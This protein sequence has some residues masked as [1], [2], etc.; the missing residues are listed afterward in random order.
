[1]AHGG[2][3]A[4]DMTSHKGA[5]PASRARTAALGTRIDELVS[6][7][8]RMGGS[9]LH[10]KVGVPPGIRAQGLLR[11]L[12]EYGGLR[13]EDTESLLKEILPK[14]MATEFEDEGE[15][16]FSYEVS[17]LGRFRVNAFRQRGS[18]SI[19]M[20]YIPL[21]VPKFEELALPEVIR[22]LA[23][24]ERGIILV[25]GTTGSGKSTTLASM[26]DLVNHSMHK[27]IVTI[28]DP[29]E[30]LHRDDKSFI[31]QREVGSDTAS[32]TR[33]LRRVLRQDPDIILIGEIRDAESAQIALSA[34]ETGHLVLS[35][36][37][38]VDATETVNRMIDLFPAHERAPVR[39][40]LAGTLKGIIGQRL[41]RTTDG[42]RT[43]ACEVMI[44]TGRIQ[45]FIVDS[46]QTALI[47]QAIMEGEYYG[48]QTFD[49]ALLKLVEEGRIDFKEALRASTRP[50]DFKLMVQSLGLAA[51]VGG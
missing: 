37:H 8:V 42:K 6:R 25:T 2:N 38:T 33:A 18:V 39:T 12:E 49:Q 43:P 50:Q 20:R 10:L 48:M 46:E 3:H 22:T 35:T 4:D 17:G 24:E 28:E 5:D 40:M 1:M 23:F 51:R 19:A 29:I 26:I 13:P 21:G 14:R 9:D 15:V 44:S 47:Q 30:Y 32:Y 27:H 41:V 45:D 34:A 31:S 36:L 7:L 11:P 16:D